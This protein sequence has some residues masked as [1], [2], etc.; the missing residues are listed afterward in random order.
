MG[1]GVFQASGTLVITNS[2]FLLNQVQGD[3]GNGIEGVPASPAY[4]GALAIIGGTLSIDH[5]QFITNQAIGG[6]GEECPA[7]S[8]YGG[9]V[10][11]VTVGTVNDSTFVGNQALG[12]GNGIS[13]KGS[14]GCGGGIYNGGSLTLNGCSLYSNFAEGGANDGFVDYGSVVGGDGLGAGIYNSA[15]LAATNCTLALNVATGATSESMNGYQTT[16]GNANGGGIFNGAGALFVGM[17][18]TVASNSCSSPPGLTSVA[19]FVA[20][21]QIA[22]T[23]GAFHVHNSI[24]AYGTNSNAYGPITDD[25]YNICSD[26]SANLDGGSSFNHTDPQLAPLGNYGGPT[27]CLALLANSPAIDDADPYDFPTTDQ[28]GYVRPFG[29]GPDIGAYE[30]GSTFPG[31]PNLRVSTSG[32]NLVVSFAAFPPYSYRL[33]CSTDLKSWSDLSTNG[34]IGSSTN[35]NQTVSKQGFNSRYFRLRMQ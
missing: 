2:S 17:N 16:S 26:A 24:I 5:S 34:P 9:G 12:G 10:Y 29:A 22:N 28:R 13:S 6:S 14:T 1:V 7:A 11:C 23:N 19:G 25:G 31:A 8:A 32:T 4:G 27:L 18:L 35:I 20:G 33:Q 15:L 3:A 30:Y 21:S